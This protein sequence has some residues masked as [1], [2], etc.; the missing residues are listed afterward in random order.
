M[1][2]EVREGGE[3]PPAGRQRI[4]DSWSNETER[5]VT[6]RSETAF[7]NLRKFL[8]RHTNSFEKNV[9]RLFEG[10]NA[11]VIIRTLVA[12]SNI[13]SEQFCDFAN[14]RH[15]W[16]TRAFPP[17]KKEWREKAQEVM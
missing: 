3:I 14:L 16:I 11:T 1:G 7:R 12:E 5:T 8:V 10:R 15:G 2:F 6:D 17:A 13:F 4:P 9:G